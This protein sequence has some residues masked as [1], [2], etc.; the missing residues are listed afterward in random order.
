MR[1][2]VLAILFLLFCISTIVAARTADE[3]TGDG[4]P[5][6]LV[7]GQAP[8]LPKPDPLADPRA[9]DRRPDRHHP[10]TRLVPEDQRCFHHEVADPALA[11]IVHVGPAD[12]DRGHLDQYLVG[13]RRR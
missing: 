2:K 10:A 4:P 1:A 12:P 13:F 7:P 3:D 11:V 6:A 8:P 9:P 5:P